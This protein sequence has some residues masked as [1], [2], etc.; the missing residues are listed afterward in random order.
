MRNIDEGL[1]HRRR[2][3]GWPHVGLHGAGGQSGGAPRPPHVPKCSTANY[4]INKISSPPATMKPPP[5]IILSSG[6]CLKRIKEIT[7]DTTKKIAI[8]TPI[9]RL[10]SRPL[11]L[12]TIPYAKSV[13]APAAI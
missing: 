4:V 12:T 9:R 7:W 8:Y 1:R 2:R 5:R 3:L 10:K 6:I 11:L 13:T